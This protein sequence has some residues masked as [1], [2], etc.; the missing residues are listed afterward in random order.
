MSHK[1][2][3]LDEIQNLIKVY[4]RDYVVATRTEKF[5]GHEVELVITLGFLE[6]SALKEMSTAVEKP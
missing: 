5:I 2:L 1:K 3:S 6:E 4:G